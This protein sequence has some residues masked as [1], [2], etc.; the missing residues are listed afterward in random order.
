MKKYL[1]SA[2][3][4][5]VLSV[6]LALPVFAAP[7]YTLSG[8]A[9]EAGG[10]VTLVS[11]ASPGYGLI[12]YAFTGSTFASLSQLATDFNVTDDDC[13]GGSP[14]FQLPIDTDNN[15]ISNG[16][17]FIYLGPSPSFS[18]CPQNTWIPSGNLVGNNDACRFD[19]SQLAAGTQCNTYNG[20]LAAFGTGKILGVRI[21]VDSGWGFGDGEQT[22]KIDNV[23]INGDT[24]TFT[25][26]CTPVDNTN[27]SG[28]WKLDENA[29]VV[30]IDSAGADNNGA[31][32]NG[33]VYVAGNPAI[34]PNPSALSFD[35]VDDQV[36]ISNSQDFRF[37]TGSFTV[38]TFVKTGTGNTSVLGNF[39]NTM[40]GW[41][42]YFYQT[43]QINF[44][45]YGTSGSNDTSHAAPG[46]MDNQWHHVAGVYTHSGANLTIAA[47][48]D[49]ALI[50][51]NTIATGDITS[52]SDLLLGKYLLQPNYEGVLDDVRVYGRTL[53]ASEIANLSNG[54]TTPAS[55]SSSSVSSSSSSSS[56]SSSSSSSVS[57]SSSSSSSSVAPP[58]CDGQTATIYVQGGT[59]VGGPD[60]GDPYTGDLEG[61]NSDDVI[62][63]TNNDDEIDGDNGNDIICGRGGEDEID[64]DRGNDRVFGEGGADELDGSSG[65]DTLTGGGD[66]DELNGGLG[67]DLLVGSTGGDELKGGSGIDTLCG[68]GN[69]DTLK[70][71][72]ANDKL[73]GGGG[74]DTLKGD[75]GSDQCV[76]GESLSS[77]EN[78]SGSVP[79]CT[80]L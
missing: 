21:V 18:G 31:H 60:N 36:R 24:F 48:Y 67:D 62:V 34:S 53:S 27:L 3:A 4:L 76:N 12:S 16:N 47:Y 29:G 8:E 70:G 57:S 77:C 41:G 14:R 33:P 46:L 42:L 59:I 39:S 66:A 11:D 49:G 72:S 56:V 65:N 79:A 25:P 43:N 28:Y 54:C 64:G 73:D 69:G 78:T 7:T 5:A 58:T 63:G 19:T 50:G 40:R 22:V 23:Q 80:G 55:S 32:E 9:T 30:A 74:T 45:G 37:G 68:G 51:T 35:G 75:G 20:A 26:P 17:M 1:A 13:Y 6:T 52:T 71:G 10:V 61:T 38:S 15:G 2:S 44:F